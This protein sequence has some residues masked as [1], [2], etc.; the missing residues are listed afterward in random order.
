MTLERAWCPWLIGA[1][2]DVAVEC[3]FEPGHDHAD[4]LK[5]HRSPGAHLMHDLLKPGGAA[6]GIGADEHIRRSGRKAVDHGLR[7]G[8]AESFKSRQHFVD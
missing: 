4:I 6:L 5:L 2:V 8:G 3:G 7:L 1:G